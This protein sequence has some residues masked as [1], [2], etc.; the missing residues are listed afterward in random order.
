MEAALEQGPP[1][2]DP[3]PFYRPVLKYLRESDPAAFAA[4]LSHYRDVLVPA[5]ADGAEPLARWLDYGRLLAGALGPGQTVEVDPTGRAREIE[6]IAEAD[7]LV[8]HL[9]V[10]AAAP[11]LVLRHPRE[12]TPHQDAT[13][14]LLAAGRVTASAYEG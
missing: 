11:V 14:E 13:V 10:A 12:T 8:L 5:V 4:A 3:R 1:V 2:R 7:G 6:E 9:P